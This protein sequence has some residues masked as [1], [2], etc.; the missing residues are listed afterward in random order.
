VSKL[1]SRS[2][3]W[4]HPILSS[5]SRSLK[6]SLRT[7]ALAALVTVS[8]RAQSTTEIIRGRVLGLEKN[9]VADAEVLVTGLA[10]RTSQRVR[11]DARGN[12]TVLFQNAE[13][14]YLVA[15]RKIGFVT[16][17][18]RLSRTGI[19]NV[20][21]IDF[22]MQPAARMLDTVQVMTGDDSTRRA[23]SDVGS[24]NLAEEL[25]LT[26]PRNLMSLLLSIPG[27]VEHADAGR[28][29]LYRP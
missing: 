17:M 1:G 4:G 15:V 3:H 9:P 10:T 25:F 29:E 16:G 12:F 24:S 28:R 11:T 23:A 7:V 2:I 22:Q 19:S 21:S 6:L 20:L 13:A 14:D 5:I 8:A 27:I 18:Q 26:D